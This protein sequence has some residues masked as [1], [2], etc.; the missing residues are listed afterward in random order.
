MMGPMTQAL[1]EDRFKW[2]IRRESREVPAY[3]L[4]VAK[5][6]SKLQTPFPSTSRRLIRRTPTMKEFRFCLPCSVTVVDHVE[7]TPTDN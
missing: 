2:K 7:K 1:L 3:A 4:T 6:G 5:G